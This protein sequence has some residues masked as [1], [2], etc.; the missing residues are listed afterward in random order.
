MLVIGTV[1]PGKRRREEELPSE[2]YVRKAM[3]HSLGTFD[4]TMI[5][6]MVMFFINNPVGTVG[7]GA[8]A[9][10]YWIIGA[11]AFFLPC[12][13]ATAQLGTMFSHDGSLYNWTQ[14]ALGSFWS[15]FVGVSF[16]VPG[17]LGM[18][19]S[20]GIAVTLLQGLNSNWLAEPRGQG[21]FI[22]FILI[23]SAI[24]SMQR[25]R[26]VQNIVNM[27]TILMLC[28]IAL[29][30]LAALIWLATG[31][32]VATSITRAS[33]LAIQ[34][35]NYVLFSTVI[36]AFLGANVSM[37]LGSEI[38]DLKV[39]SHHLFRGGLLVL[40]SY[41]IVT[42]ALLVVEGP[43]AA[44]SG[45]FSII[46][47]IDQVFGKFIG[48]IAVTCVIAFF[49]ILT[50]LLNSIFARLLLIGALDRRLPISLGK[51]DE[52]RVPLNAIIFQTAVAVLFAAIVFLLPYLISLG[53]PV[54]LS[55]EL[56][57][58]SLYAHSMVWAI[59]SSFLFINLLVLYLRDRRSFHAQRIFP[60]PVL[61]ACIIVAPLASVLAIIVTLSYSPIPQL[62]PSNIWGGI[63]GGL[64]VGWLV[65]AGIASMVANSEAS[66]EDLS[67]DI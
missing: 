17:I 12:I 29:L 7:A 46:S 65:F 9:F 66:W 63:V 35:G 51:L 42:L 47:T 41:L 34:P 4:M 58:V 28:V 62:I 18:V 45:P 67:A 52:N 54:N 38:T 64:T 59:S 13:I 11:L 24:L 39:V 44:S 3:P 2:G 50:A 55:N 15:F 60:M 32:H 21:V 14:K 25:F 10:T 8:A 19:G 49:I 37:T 30:G 53:N 5:F 36:L 43:Q 48:G 61:W 22:V 6:L 31:H 23:L 56:F 40:A 27:T 33:D 26:V 16:W 57:T 1:L 20:A